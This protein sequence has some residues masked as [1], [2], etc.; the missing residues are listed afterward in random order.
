MQLNHNSE[1]I[2]TMWFSVFLM[3]S[4]SGWRAEQQ[5]ARQ[6]VCLLITW[7]FALRQSVHIYKSNNNNIL[8]AEI[9]EL[10][11][12]A[13][14]SGRSKSQYAT[15]FGLSKKRI[16][17]WAK[18]DRSFFRM[19]CLFSELIVDLVEGISSYYI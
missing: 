14:V 8:Q 7:R 15:C 13:D 2:S 16:P 3:L 11:S 12:D 19:Q 6:S 5:R 1:K 4:V 10:N 17:E 18:C 9:E